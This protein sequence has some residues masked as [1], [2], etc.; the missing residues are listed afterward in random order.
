M[1]MINGVSCPDAI[2]QTLAG[3]LSGCGLDPA[4]VAVLRGEDIVPR[5]AFPQT[6]L[7]DGEHIEIVQFVGG[8]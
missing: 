8:G 2:G 3:Y 5:D 6:V 7:A 4:R 1:L